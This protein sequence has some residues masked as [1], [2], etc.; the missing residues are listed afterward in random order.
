MVA[1]EALRIFI[2]RGREL[3]LKAPLPVIATPCSA[4]NAD[5][6]VETLET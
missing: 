3:Q 1:G 2:L 6:G 4:N 5:D